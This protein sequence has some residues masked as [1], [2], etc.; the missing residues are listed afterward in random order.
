MAA[1]LD[2]TRQRIGQVITHARER[3]S[4]FPSI[5]ALRDAIYEILC[6]QGGVATHA[7]LVASVLIA[8]GS[9]FEE[10]KRTQ[11]ASVAVRAALEAERNLAEP[12]FQEHRSDRHIFISITPQL[13]EF[14]SMLGSVADELATQEPIPSPTSVVTALRA[15]QVPELP[16]NVTAPTENRLCQLA[17]AASDGAAL[18]SRREIYPVGLAPERS[19]ALAQNA[20][21]GGVLTVEE[22]KNRIAARY[23]Q[24]AP[25][26]DRPKLDQLIA[27]LGLDLK[28]N[29]AAADGRGAYE[30]PGG[31]ITSLYTS[32]L[33]NQPAC[34]PA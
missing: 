2:V 17:V 23:P 31:E 25:L 32:R 15:I 8:R 6:S 28:W 5:T 14:A 22:I 34:T 13:K 19:L 7:E 10:P 26:P 4:R 3:W 24:A 12:R 29:P 16:E 30:M 33:D 27:S 21:F 20:F 1:K 18:S 9:T 11:M